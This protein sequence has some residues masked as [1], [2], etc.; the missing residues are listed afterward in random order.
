MTKRIV[1]V[2]TGRISEEISH[3]MVGLANLS[4][5][6]LVEDAT[7]VGT[8]TL[9]HVGKLPGLLTAAHVLDVLPSTGAVAIVLFQSG[10]LQKQVIPM[11]YAVPVV[12]RGEEFTKNGPDMGFL[13][14]P[15]T[16]AGSLSAIG[17]SY[18]LKKWSDSVFSDKKPAPNYVE[19]LVGMIGALTHES[20]AEKPH[21]RAKSFSAVFCDAKEQNTRKSDGYDLVDVAPVAYPDFA[22]PPN[23]E[24][25]SGGALWRMYFIERGGTPQIITKH[26][27]GIPFYQSVNANGSTIIT[28]HAATGIY[29]TLVETIEDRRPDETK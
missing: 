28:C 9:V 8:A 7:L 11:E 24:G 15:P 6:N 23:F 26:L 21:R 13:R 5:R 20:P 14:L 16:I 19:A 27:V 2:P 4:V 10:K 18:N 17:L 3:Y 1:Q 22:L 25:M 12:I 29:K